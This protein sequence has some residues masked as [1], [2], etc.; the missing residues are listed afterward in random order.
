MNA[1]PWVRR[2]FPS[3]LTREESDASIDTFTA[4]L[5][6]HGFTLYAAELRATGEF[7]GLIGLARIP[8]EAHFTPCVE[9]GWRLDPS[10]WN[11]GLATEGAR[12]CLRFAFEDLALDEV[13]ALTVPANLAS[14][15]VMEKLGMTRN[16]DDDFDHPGVPE[17]HPIRRHVLYRIRRERT[18]PAA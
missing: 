4:H 12:E 15:R 14:R 2:Y 1:D 5:A 7:I 6:E 17:G 10:H 16:P 9:I 18:S 3:V 13:V 11:R 8:W